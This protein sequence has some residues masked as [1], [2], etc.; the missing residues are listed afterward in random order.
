MAQAM[1][2][3]LATPSTKPFFPE[4]IPIC[5]PF[6]LIGPNSLPALRPASSEL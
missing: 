6:R 5:G 2:K 1:L 3:S 4:N